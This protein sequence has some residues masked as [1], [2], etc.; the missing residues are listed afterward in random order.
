MKNLLTLIM[1]VIALSSYSPKSYGQDAG[2]YQKINP[3]EQNENMSSFLQKMYD[4]KAAEQLQQQR[5]QQQE[6][7]R[8][9]Q[10]QE[11][12]QRQAQQQKQQQNERSVYNPDDYDIDSTKCTKVAGETYQGRQ[13]Y[14]SLSGKLF[15]CRVSKNNKTYKEYLKKEE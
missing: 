5:L 8:Q 7:E 11:Q 13:I 1:M 4:Q 3:L 2:A 10:Q 6:Q 12:E 9:R 14:Q 15:V